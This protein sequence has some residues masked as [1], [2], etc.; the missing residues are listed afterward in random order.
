MCRRYSI[1]NLPTLDDLIENCLA[2][3]QGR[4]PKGPLIAMSC[5][6]GGSKGL[7]LDY[8]SDEGAAMAPLTSETKAKLKSMID[9]G[10]TAENPLDTG[11]SVDQWSDAGNP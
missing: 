11:P 3:G 1:I 2:F 6:S 8:A 10:L 9:P 7:A 5:C 4:L